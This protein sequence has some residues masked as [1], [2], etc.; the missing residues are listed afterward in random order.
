M[1]VCYGVDAYMTYR[2][3]RATAPPGSRVPGESRIWK[4]VSPSED[5]ESEKELWASVMLVDIDDS[6]CLMNLN[7]QS[8][9]HASSRGI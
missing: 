4:A 6:K 3:T 5:R 8:S 2:M 9:S 7:L 1:D